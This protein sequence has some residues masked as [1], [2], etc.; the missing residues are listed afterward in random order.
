[1]TPPT[2]RF[3]LRNDVASAWTFFNPV[4]APGE[5]GVESDTG[6]GKIGDGATA[7]SSLPYAF[8]PGLAAASSLPTGP[9]A[10]TAGVVIG[11][12]AFPASDSGFQAAITAARHHFN[13]YG[14]ALCILVPPGKYTVTTSWPIHNSFTMRCTEAVR[15]VVQGTKVQITNTTADFFTRQFN[16]NDQ[17]MGEWSAGGGPGPTAIYPGT[18]PGDWAV[19][20]CVTLNGFAYRC[21]V[22][23]GS[24][25]SGQGPAYLG[26]PG[27]RPS[28]GSNPYLSTSNKWWQASP[29]YT[30]VDIDGIAFFGNAQGL[31]TNWSFIEPDNGQGFTWRDPKITNCSMSN[32]RSVMIGTFGRLLFDHARITVCGVADVYQG[33][34]W[35]DDG[36]G[37]SAIAYTATTSVYYHDPLSSD[38]NS[39]SGW[40]FTA[41]GN[42]PVGTAHPTVVAGLPQDDANWTV[43]TA[44]LCTTSWG[45][46]DSK[47]WPSE[48]FVSTA[49]VPATFPLPSTAVGSVQTYAVRNCMSDTEQVSDY[50]TNNP[51]SGVRVD[52]NADGLMLHPT[53]GRCYSYVNNAA[54]KLWA[55]GNGYNRY[56]I[57]AG[58]DG[59]SYTSMVYQQSSSVDPASDHDG[60]TWALLAVGQPSGSFG[61]A[62]PHLVFEASVGRILVGGDYSTGFQD[63]TR[64]TPTATHIG[65]ISIRNSSDISILE[66]TTFDKSSAPA[67]S[68]WNDNASLPVDLIRIGRFQVTNIANVRVVTNTGTS[69]QQLSALGTV[70]LGSSHQSIGNLPSNSATYGTA[71]VTTNPPRTPLTQIAW[72]GIDLVNYALLGCTYAFN[73][74]GGSTS[75]TMP[76]GAAIVYTANYDT[77]PKVALGRGVGGASL[78]RISWDDWRHGADLQ[79]LPA[80]LGGFPTGWQLFTVIP[81]AQTVTPDW[82]TYKA[83]SYQLSGALSLGAPNNTGLSNGA[84]RQVEI[85]QDDAGGWAVSVNGTYWTLTGGAIAT[86]PKSRTVLTFTLTGGVW[87]ESA[88]SVT[89]NPVLTVNSSAPDASGN[90]ALP[91]SGPLAVVSYAPGTRAQPNTSSSTFAPID[92]THLSATYIC[93]ASGQVKVKVN[94]VVA[95][96]TA[97]GATQWWAIADHTTGALVSSAAWIW[98]GLTITAQGYEFLVTKDGNGNPLVPGNSY[99]VD[100]VFADGNNGGSSSKAQLNIV[101]AATASTAGSNVGGPALMVVSAA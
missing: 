17:P 26:T 90:L 51:M 1:M 61:A 64:I 76:A 39:N 29:A 52:G 95:N 59:N 16:S 31:H 33:L 2:E 71:T 70:P 63:L 36:T 22:S 18:A 40:N 91:T 100:W 13:Q 58:S 69:G 9:T 23:A 72:T 24:G 5:A 68:I 27:N 96:Q 32:F 89:L 6:N 60:T 42:L 54:P 12:A 53:R 11:S 67:V 55:S 92:A 34:P 62:G 35:M 25:Q 10:P 94:G 81:S 99:T 15:S 73:G 48:G 79:Y 88:R 44:F 75:D 46:S 30:A 7:W 74:N 86:T 66:G 45:G 20:D 41:N 19:G 65:Q 57:V 78:T 4:L 87:V 50:I 85:V 101:A 56:A 8:G 49:A 21:L 3:E 77:N 83:N 93:P 98:S 37:H 43:S 28:N 80:L 14:T 38:L 97:A 47:C 84:L 82:V